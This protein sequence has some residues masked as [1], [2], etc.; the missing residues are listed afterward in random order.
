MDVRSLWFGLVLCFSTLA[1][2]SLSHMGSPLKKHVR[3]EFIV[4]IKTSAKIDSLLQLSPAYKDAKSIL[5]S[6]WVKDLNAYKTLLSFKKENDVIEISS[7]DQEK[8]TLWSYPLFQFQGDPRESIPNDPE[9]EKQLH[10]G[11]MKNNLAWDLH[12]GSS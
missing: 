12:K 4:A 10:H 3:N 2:A 9:F 7:L 11:V 1:N 6:Y 5:A 8:E